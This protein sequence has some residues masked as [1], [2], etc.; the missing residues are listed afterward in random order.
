MIQRIQS[1]FLLAT[2]IITA[3]L[4]LSPMAVLVIPNNFSY[5][6]YTCKVMRLDQ[7]PVFM[8][9]N[10]TSMILNIFITGLAI[11]TIFLYKKR[12]LQVRLCLV[13]IILM[14][15]LLLLMC[16]QIFHM[17]NEL[18]ADRIFRLTISFPI[19]GIILTWLALRAIV[20]DIKLLKSLD[21]IR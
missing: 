20:K 3:L 16:Y 8:T 13:N 10:W 14:L 4:F 18:D 9:Y 17:T 12:F 11:V 21:R 2:A 1:L 19:V 6:F 7:I 5:E 15:G